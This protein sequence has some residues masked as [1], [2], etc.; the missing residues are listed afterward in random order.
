MG[1]EFGLT[2]LRHGSVD[3]TVQGIG[4]H[5]IQLIGEPLVE[6]ASQVCCMVRSCPV[7]ETMNP[8]EEFFEFV[9]FDP[10]TGQLVIKPTDKLFARLAEQ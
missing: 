8:P 10:L 7:L 5:R 4:S 9:S 2:T 3:C 1:Q 6:A